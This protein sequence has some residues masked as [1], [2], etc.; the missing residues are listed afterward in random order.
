MASQ[1]QPLKLRFNHRRIAF[2]LA[3]LGLFA[4]FTLLFTLPSAVPTSPSL[5]KS[6][7][8]HKFSLPH[9]PEKL[10]PFKPPT[11][12]PKQQKN[13][14]YGGSTWYSNWNWRDPFSW[15]T[16]L[17]ENRSLLPPLRDRTPIYC[18]YD[19]TVDRDDATKD[20]ESAL[21]LTWRRAW[22]AQGFRPTIL[23]A[24]E[25]MHN[26]LY[27]E[28][29]GAEMEPRLKKDLMAWLAWDNMGDG[30][31]ASYLL[32]P[33]GPR[34]DPLLTFL[35]RGEYPEM[36][37]WEDFSD[38]LFIGPP[39]MVTKA[40]NEALQNRQR[41]TSKNFISAVASDTFKVDPSHDSLVYYDRNTVDRHFSK[42]AEATIANRAEGL[43]SL[44]LLINSH[45][46]NTWQDSFDKGIAVLKPLPTH[47]T[48]MIEP[49]VRLARR[50]ATC[51]DSP[52]PA[53]CPPNLPRCSPCVSSYPMQIATPA[54]HRNKTRIYTIGTVPHPY[55]LRTLDSLRADLDVG[56]IRRETKR[57]QWL[58]VV[59]QEILGTGTTAAARVV[60]FKDAVAGDY[61]TAHSLWLVG[62]EDTVQNEIDWWFGFSVP[63]N[64][65]DDGKSETPVPG[66]ERRPKPIHDPADGPVPKDDEL[67]L[68]PGLLTRA[69]EVQGSKVEDE[70]RIRDVVEAWNMAD[71]EAWRF[72]KAFM[73]R[74]ELERQQWEKEESKFAGGAGSDT[75][76]ERRTGRTRWK[77]DDKP[78][79]R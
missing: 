61:A 47:T 4:L 41:K 29:Q 9:Y 30:L 5:S 12:K 23:G 25:A 50:L 18:Y 37:R 38:G 62:G 22:W 69:L 1:G 45:L 48:T 64:T 73:A 75:G 11:H 43:R 76:D 40:I 7:A 53:S 10:N 44:N 56:F 52:L 49:G 17:E 13:S 16:T 60:K 19:S 67:A 79:Q 34:Q 65:T 8:D 74:S 59:F 6:L 58:Y 55:M 57:D 78:S 31:L 24:A 26:P 21:L 72:A 54:R 63:K 71:T 27:T 66:P 14:E 77:D 33:M 36:T 39:P 32:L 35:R 42:I 70:V 68:E 51:H 46:H 20:A 3:G 28:L 2:L 15:T